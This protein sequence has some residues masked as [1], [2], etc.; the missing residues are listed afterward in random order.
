MCNFYHTP[1]RYREVRMSASG[2]PYSYPVNNCHKPCHSRGVLDLSTAFQP[3]ITPQNSRK[4]HK[5]TPILPRS[6]ILGWML[7]YLGGILR[8]PT[9]DLVMSSW[10]C[11]LLAGSDDGSIFGKNIK[12][13]QN[14]IPL[15]VWDAKADIFVYILHEG[16]DDL[17]PFS[18]FSEV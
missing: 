18:V 11:C 12:Y 9:R 8:R 16:G 5:F 3:Q 2:N 6:A 7:V 10:L 14:D 17:M 15:A 1:F 4:S 13:F